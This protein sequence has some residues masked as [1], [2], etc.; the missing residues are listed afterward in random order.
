MELLNNKA[1][2]AAK[3][4]EAGVRASHYKSPYMNKMLLLSISLPKYS[5]EDVERKVFKHIIDNLKK[6]IV[7]IL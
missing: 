4:K 1:S 5:S 3:L 2:I 6:R 7:D